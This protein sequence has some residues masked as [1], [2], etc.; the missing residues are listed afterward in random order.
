[1]A[2]LRE[3]ARRIALIYAALLGGTILVSAAVGL[4]GGTGL[5]RSIS[6]GLYLVGALLLLG[7]FLSGVRGPLRGIS[8]S[9]ETVPAVAARGLRRASLLERSEASQLSLL[10]FVLG[11]SLIVLGALVDPVHRAF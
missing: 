1:M 8:R 3:A 10:L 7:C 6:V 4:A 9:G 2:A 11:L 5:L